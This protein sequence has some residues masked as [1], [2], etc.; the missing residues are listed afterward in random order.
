ML[1]YAFRVAMQL[2][3]NRH[4][5]EDLLRCLVDLYKELA[6]PEIVQ[7]CQCL[8]YLDDPL[9]VANVLETLS[10]VSWKSTLVNVYWEV[11]D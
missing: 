8:I 1:S 2:I 10:Q 3:Q 11:G 6:K 7:M 4:Y 9:S 5:R